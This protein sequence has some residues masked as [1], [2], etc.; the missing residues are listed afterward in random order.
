MNRAETSRTVEFDDSLL[1]YH[2]IGEGSPILLLGCFGPRPGT[3]A[4]LVYERALTYLSKQF[5]CIVMDLPN[6]GSSRATA[7]EGEPSHHVIARNAIALLDHLGIDA[8]PVVGN[9]VG[10][11]TGIVMGIE[12][13]ERVAKLV[14]GGCHASTGG[15][16]YLLAPSPPNQ[17][18]VMRLFREEQD[19]APDR[20][21]IERLMRAIVFNEELITTE[22]I[23]QMYQARLDAPPASTGAN[24]PHS[25]L[26]ELAQLSMPMLI[27][28]GR[29][30]RMVPIEQGLML[31]SYVSQSTFIGINNCGHWPPF[32]Q[33]ELYANYVLNFLTSTR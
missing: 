16:P 5:R 23:D 9:S 13:P 1:H 26:A 28:H 10:G 15:D 30:D 29:F 3:S 14:V 7:R 27:V 11:T 6:Y 17:A 22:M 18:E 24:V 25:N 33:P 12:Y 20:T 19:S 8:L 31:F 32:D 2:D 21:K 4:W